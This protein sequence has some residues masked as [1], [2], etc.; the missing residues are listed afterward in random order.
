M[1]VI[2]GITKVRPYPSKIPRLPKLNLP[3][4]YY[5]QRDGG[6]MDKIVTARFFEVRR[7]NIR[8]PRFEHVLR[9]LSEVENLP[10]RE[11]H[12]GTDC[13]ARLER[14]EVMGNF[15]C[16]EI[17]RIQKTNYPSEVTDDGLRPLG[18]DGHLGH[19]V[20]FVYS[21]TTA[22]L[23]MQF[24]PRTI[25][26]S[27]FSQY[28]SAKY[29]GAIYELTP[30][31]RDDAWERF[32]KSPTRKVEISVAS[33]TM[34]ADLENEEGAVADVFR[35]LAEVYQAPVINLT[36]SVGHSEKR[37]LSERIKGMVEWLRGKSAEGT[38]DVRKLSAVPADADKDPI[39]LLDDILTHR[40]TL[41]LPDNEP[42]LNWR[43]RNHWLMG[44]LG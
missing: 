6:I 31:V 36:L 20:A 32:T 12:L 9:T 26:P 38:L 7:H 8:I 17:T 21:T 4:L 10:D 1:L 41:E 40:A 11:A 15:L 22:R 13:Y 39:D 35:Q 42:N 5:M 19:G 44:L 18:L 29:D 30:V 34:I 37:V 24:N 2:F 16:G 43:T 3:C 25:S 33:P 14:L 27:R 23:A 28:L